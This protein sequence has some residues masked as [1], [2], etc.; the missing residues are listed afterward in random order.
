MTAAAFHH[1]I[2]NLPGAARARA[3]ADTSG[4]PVALLASADAPW[5]ATEATDVAGPAFTVCRY[6]DGSRTEAHPLPDSAV[7]SDRGRERFVRALLAATVPDGKD[8]GYLSAFLQGRLQE[9]TVRVDGT[10]RCYANVVER[11]L[12]LAV[13]PDRAGAGTAPN[14]VI[15]H[16]AAP[17]ADRGRGAAA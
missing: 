7:R 9:S 14:L 6:E 13:V 15:V 17:A 4:L 8:A 12:V 1:D 5:T 3:V 16:P 11:S 10:W 2:E